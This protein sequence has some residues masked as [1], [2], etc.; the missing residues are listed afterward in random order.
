PERMRSLDPDFPIRGATASRRAVKDK[1]PEDTTFVVPVHATESTGLPPG[2]QAPASVTLH[3]NSF[4]GQGRMDLTD[5]SVV[6]IIST[7][8]WRRPMTFSFTAGNLHWLTP[9]AR[10]EGLYWRIFPVADVPVD[11]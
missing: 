1:L 11:L 5:L 10:P 7:N 8:G 3:A 6:D 2:M 4:N 9:Y